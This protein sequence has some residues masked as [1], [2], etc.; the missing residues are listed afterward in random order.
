MARYAKKCRLFAHRLL[1]LV[2]DIL[3]MQACSSVC[4]SSSLFL[5]NVTRAVPVF[6]RIMS[7]S[8]NPHMSDIV[9][10]K[11]KIEPYLAY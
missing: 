5:V 2:A 3:A 7:T 11:T 4:H 10:Q 8:K 9:Q 6:A 1:K